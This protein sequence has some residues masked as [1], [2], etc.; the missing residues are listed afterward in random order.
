MST[1][2]SPLGSR[3][4]D[5]QANEDLDSTIAALEGGFETL[6]PDTGQRIVAL[7][8]DTLRRSDWPSAHLVAQG[9]EELHELLAMDEIDGAAVGDVMVSLAESTRVANADTDERL[10][11]RLD[12]LATLLETVGRSLGGSTVESQT[13]R[14]EDSGQ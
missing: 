2:S 9:L 8:R 10:S 7:W 14:V 11:P 3:D 6:N 5:L 1:P 13:P 12:Q 4:A